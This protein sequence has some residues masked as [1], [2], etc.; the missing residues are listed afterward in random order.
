MILYLL[1]HFTIGIFSL[2]LIGTFLKKKSNFCIPVFPLLSFRLNYYFSAEQLC[3]TFTKRHAWS[4]VAKGY[5]T[6]IRS[7]IISGAVKLRYNKVH[8]SMK[9]S[10]LLFWVYLY[11]KKMPMALTFA[12]LNL[13]NGPSSFQQPFEI[14]SRGSD[15]PPPPAS[16]DIEAQPSYENFTSH[17]QS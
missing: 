16:C 5:S 1:N 9:F 2:I 4:S 6:I 8:S 15:P 14:E 11:V 10:T 12:S 3:G 13:T 7:I 17:R